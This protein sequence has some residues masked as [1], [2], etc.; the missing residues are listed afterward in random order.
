MDEMQQFRIVAPRLSVALSAGNVIFTWPATP[1]LLLET[2]AVLV[3]A[4]WTPVTPAPSTVGNQ[5]TLLL[6]ITG[7]SAFY[8]LRSP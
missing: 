8:R 7:N 1:N 4:S 5:K 6:P 3:P 2:T